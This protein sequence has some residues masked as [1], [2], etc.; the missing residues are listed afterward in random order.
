M[1]TVIL[2]A[3]SPVWEDSNGDQRY[4]VMQVAMSSVRFIPQL[5]PGDDAYA[6]RQ[7]LDTL[8]R[9]LN[10]INVRSTAEWNALVRWAASYCY[11]DITQWGKSAELPMMDLYEPKQRRTWT[12][13]QPLLP[14]N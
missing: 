6:K 13:P 4:I 2:E 14:H 10:P 12:R 11:V 9:C 1:T 5:V 3:F 7:R 8:H